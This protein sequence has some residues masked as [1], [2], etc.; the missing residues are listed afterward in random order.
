MNQPARTALLD[1]AVRVFARNPAASLEDVA[2]AAGVGR[3]TLFRHFRT[4]HELLRAV[5]VRSIDELAGALA[6]EVPA[7]GPADERLAR[8]LEVLVGRGDRL[9][10]LLV[11]AELVNDPEVDS[12][13]GRILELALPILRDA[14]DAGHLRADCPLEWHVS[15]MEA[16]VYA[17]W[18]EVAAGRLAPA[19]A[20]GL[21]LDTCLR[22]LGAR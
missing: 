16:V 15:A 14:V 3:A 19:H 21:V 4:R 20:P 11:V 2:A 22:G 7:D 18:N 9:R 5:A 10:F 1:A 8:F 12:A 13:D 6:A 17:A